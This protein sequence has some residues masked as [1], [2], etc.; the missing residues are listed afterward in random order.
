MSFLKFT[1]ESNKEKEHY[2]VFE[3][4]GE[5]TEKYKDDYIDMPS[6]INYNNFKHVF[7]YNP[8]ITKS[9]LNSLLYPKD[10]NIITVEYIP[11][12][13]PEKKTDFPE[14]LNLESLDSL[15]ADILCKCTLKNE[16]KEESQSDSDKVNEANES[17]NEENEKLDLKNEMKDFLEKKEKEENENHDDADNEN[18]IM[19]DLEMQIGYNTENT[20]IIIN[21][22]KKL[23]LKYKGKILVLSL[24]Y[25]GFENSGKNKGFMTFL[26]Q[27]YLP[28]YK[29]KITYDDYV[30]YQIDLDHSRKLI[31]KKDQNLWILNKKQT[32]NDSSEEWI[33]YL[34]LPIWCKVSQDYYYAFPKLK[35]NFFLNQYLYQAFQILIYQDDIIY[36]KNAQNQESNIKL[37]KNYIFLKKRKKQ[38]KKRSVNKDKKIETQQRQITYLQVKLS[39][40]ISELGQKKNKKSLKKYRKNKYNNEDSP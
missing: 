38:L 1:G 2:Y 31:L 8:E 33:K 24:V 20:Q 19:I 16:I 21:Y 6:P 28:D 18:I 35:K 17:Q 3:M 7:E 13:Q 5:T 34:T 9:L 30:I 27:K 36:Y 4:A 29:N 32:M 37:I 10:N 14:P 23:N 15:R 11:R 22:I 12:K 40:N 25:R 26:K 39:E